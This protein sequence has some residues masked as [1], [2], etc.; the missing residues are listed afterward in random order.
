MKKYMVVLLLVLVVVWALPALA[1]EAAPAAPEKGEAAAEQAPEADFTV[2]RLVLC[3]NVVDR[4]PVGAA[5]SF[6][7][8]VGAVYA[9]LEAADVVRDTSAVFVWYYEDAEVA[10]VDLTLRQ[11]QRWRTYSSK[12]LGGRTGNWKVELQDSAGNVLDTLS[13]QVTGV[14]EP[15]EPAEPASPQ[16]N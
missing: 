4:E 12:K 13:F 3:E 2:S 7:V 1:E 8:T 10:R 11:S 9:F 6:P 5:E 15:A 14:V 16:S